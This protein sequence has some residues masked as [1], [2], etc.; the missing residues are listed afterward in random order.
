MDCRAHIP[1]I[2]PHCVCRRVRVELALSPAERTAF[3]Y[4]WTLADP[5]QTGIVTGDAAV[6]FFSASK[7][8]ASVLGEIWSLADSANNGFLTAG[9]FSIA[10]RLIGHAQRGEVVTETLIQRSG[11]PPTFDGITLP[12]PSGSGSVPT[13]TGTGFP[14][15]VEIKA[16]DRARYTRIFASAGPQNGVL[17]GEKAKEIF[18]KSKL[19]FDKLGAIWSLADTRSRGALDLTDFIIGMYFIQNTMNGTLNSIPA[20]LPAGLYEQASGGAPSPAPGFTQFPPTSPVAAQHTGGS[21]GPISRQVTGIPRQMTGSHYPQAGQRTGQIGSPV[22]SFRGAVPGLPPSSS[23]MTTSFIQPQL[24]GAAAL[25]RPAPP[26]ASYFSSGAQW[27]VTPDEKVS[28]DRF[29]D[30]LD[31]ARKGEL[32]GQIV[33]PFFMQS[34]LNETVLAHIWDMSDITQSGSLSKDEFAV[35]MHLIN[36][37]LAGNDLPPTLPRSLVPLSLR[38]QQLPQAVDPTQSGTQKDLFSIMD[39]DADVLALPVSAASAF[40]TPTPSAPLAASRG[41]PAPFSSSSAPAPAPVPAPATPRVAQST[42]ASAA[43]S[44]FDDDFFNSSPTVSSPERIGGAVV[45]AHTA[46]ADTSETSRRLQTAEQEL[47]RFNTQRSAL[48]TTAAQNAT[49]TAEIEARLTSVKATL[50]TEQKLVQGLEEKTKAQRAEL[51]KLREDLIHE[52]SSLSAL[53]AERDELEQAL[54]RDRED[55]RDAK[56]KMAEVQAHTAQLKA[57]LEKV[58]KDARQQKGMNAIA[59]KQLTTAET[60]RQKTSAE[61]EG[62]NAGEPEEASATAAVPRGAGMAQSREGTL[63]PMDSV[64]STNPFDR[65]NTASADAPVE[66][67]GFVRTATDITTGNALGG[68]AA[69]SGAEH[70]R[71]DGNP[72]DSSA[73]PTMTTAAAAAAASNDPFGVPDAEAA[74]DA[75][76]GQTAFDDAFGDFDAP[77]HANAA[78]VDGHPPTSAPA[79]SETT[80][81]P[82]AAAAFDDDFG[83]SFDAARAPARAA[84]P[85]NMTL[86]PEGQAQKFASSSIAFD[87]AF[88][89]FDNPQPATA[90]AVPAN[91]QPATDATVS[92]ETGTEDCESHLSTSAALVGTGAVAAGGIAAGA[93]AVSATHDDDQ[94]SDEDEGPE[95]LDQPSTRPT[96]MDLSNAGDEAGHSREASAVQTPGASGS[97]SVG[98]DDPDRTLD[99]GDMSKQKLTEADSSTSVFG[100]ASGS[101]VP[102]A[103]PF[104]AS[105]SARS[106]V[107]LDS[108]EDAEGGDDA[109]PRHEKFATAVQPTEEA[110]T[111]GATS[112][113]P[114]ASGIPGGDATTSPA[115]SVKARRA[116]PPAPQRAPT[117]LSS[118][119]GTATSSAFGDDAFADALTTPVNTTSQLPEISSAAPAVTK[120]PV[121]L[122]LDE[123]ESAFNDLG[124]AMPVSASGSAAQSSA[125]PASTG[126]DDAFDTDFFFVPSF[127]TVAT[128]SA[129]PAAAPATNAPSN[130]PGDFPGASNSAVS[131]AFA[132]FDS[133]FPSA[134]T[135]ANASSGSLA[136]AFSFDDAFEPEGQQMGASTG[137]PAVPPRKADAPAARNSTH[138]SA[139]PDDAGPVKQLTAMGFARHQ[140]ITA[141]EKSNYRTDRALERLLAGK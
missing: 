70:D 113:A 91:A 141:L 74:G 116:P 139:L 88:A 128:P 79:A 10:L 43:P 81:A 130:P 92:N 6:Q 76:F 124:P 120:Q 89:D 56:K 71:H 1:S 31:T 59:K 115:A 111:P 3:A 5:Q 4:I 96:G 20:A 45:L 18:V 30:G 107:D 21:Q 29:F 28:S 16:E 8:S 38:N 137:A 82:V 78:A 87:H 97:S 126:F 15:A 85:P 9:G 41:A 51:K 42:A 106:S 133:A 104:D 101:P 12:Q 50:E 17:D 55:V 119:P 65:S 84:T 123:F 73:L 22:P 46:A 27:D 94:S 117:A 54:M 19:S 48:E 24:T 131:E 100:P 134:P 135:V 37:Q 47:E 32:H 109:R 64:K 83:N 122:A 60:E 61:L 140:V 129:A 13:R 58:R 80:S 105:P 11:P 26:P 25:Q 62:A 132:D 77:E 66:H 44:G 90:T 68:V 99:V 23:S 7:L 40:V 114:V 118:I 57:E 39:D 2:F 72:V 86:E 49:S 34:K 75:H 102:E 121:Q 53:K 136:P 33:V 52:E 103:S 36:K 125:A 35:A 63:S 69:A 108:F 138:S 127:R 14:V 112:P 95:D 98:A 110:T 67:G 93:S